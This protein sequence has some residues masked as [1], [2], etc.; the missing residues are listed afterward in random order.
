LLAAV[1][2]YNQHALR[3]PLH[4]RLCLTALLAGCAL[5]AASCAAPLGPGYVVEKQEIRVRF[6]PAA[7]S[8][9]VEA[10]YDLRNTGTR[11][12]REMEILLP[13]GRRMHHGPVTIKW[14]GAEVSTESM[15]DR[16]RN[17][18]LRL[19]KPWPV[20]EAHSLRIAYDI[21]PPAEGDE[22]L[23]FS[24]DAFY[25]PAAGWS[26]ELPQ[27][28]GLF[29]FGG[30]PPKKWALIVSVPSGFLVHTSGA[31]EKNLRHDS[32]METVRALQ[33]VEDRYP[34][35]VAGRYAAKEIRAARQKVILWSRAASDS[36]ILRQASAEL[37]RTIDSYNA[38]FGAPPSRSKTFWIVECPVT[39]SCISHLHSGGG[40]SP[41]ED[42]RDEASA[43]LASSDTV[44]V[45]PSKGAPKLAAAAAPSLAASWLG[46]G[47]NPGFYQQTAPLAQLPIFA[48]AQAREAIDGPQA[49]GETIRRALH[50]IPEGPPAGSLGNGAPET[51]AQH[52]G[53]AALRR[54]APA[55]EER[56]L[57]AKSLLFFYALQDRYGPKVF[58]DAVANMLYARASRGFDID[59]LIAAFEQEAHQ[60]VAQFV[61]LWMKHPGVPAEFRARYEHTAA[62]AEPRAAL[63]MPS[64]IRF[65]GATP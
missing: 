24:A 62:G 8:I 4:A 19:V 16:P 12:I 30:V 51:P 53:S 38:S 1:P 50:L 42:A 21:L 23:S 7:Q 46:Y 34:F 49:R 25:L 32:G 65:Q 54:G 36:G 15:P 5:W 43:E 28:S 17:S 9:R 39:G 14:D 20:S 27:I 58:H 57:R 47:R 29:G 48:A 37:T 45:D 59:D 3:L 18:V 6:A 64:A 10:D 11:P 2:R 40:T 52:P 63:A 33:T 26:P 41:D 56:A 61:R 31:M 60:N 35:V 13:G 55:E 44:L 22:G